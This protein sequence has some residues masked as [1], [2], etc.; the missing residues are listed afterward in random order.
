MPPSYTLYTPEGSFRAFAPLIA[1]EINHIDV[2]V[3]TENIE[4][5][6][7]AKSPTGKAP[8]LET[9]HGVLF[10]SPA[11]ARYIA[12]LRT[13]T[14]LLGNSFSERARVDQWVDWCSAQMELPACVLFYP[15]AGYMTVDAEVYVYPPIQ[16]NTHWALDMI[17]ILG[18]TVLTLDSS[19]FFF[20]FLCFYHDCLVHSFLH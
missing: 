14:G 9:P 20:L 5:V 15:L 12:G 10:A 1:A 6:A 11:I 8:L 4:A 19:L 18:L 17:H 3:E 2:T 7:Q 13:D 16:K